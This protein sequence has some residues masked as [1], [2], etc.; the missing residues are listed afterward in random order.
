MDRACQ[1][2]RASSHLWVISNFSAG[3]NQQNEA[4]LCHPSWRPWRFIQES[5]VWSRM[6][7]AEI[8]GLGKGHVAFVGDLA[9]KDSG[10]RRSKLKSSLN[11]L[12]CYS[13]LSFGFSWLV[14]FG[15]GVF[16]AIIEIFPISQSIHIALS[17]DLCSRIAH[18]LWL[19]QQGWDFFPWG[20]LLA[21]YQ[22]SKDYFDSHLCRFVC[23]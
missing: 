13:V 9:R 12:S 15:W 23:L 8:S 17:L 5:R 21:L 16:L 3:N 6:A 18:V 20:S 22:L 4:H 11:P 1:W 7:P 2:G 10:G 19:W 14:A